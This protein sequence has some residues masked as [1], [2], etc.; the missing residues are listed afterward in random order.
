MTRIREYGDIEDV[1]YA[2]APRATASPRCADWSSRPRD[3]GRFAGP[4]VDIIV[5]VA[6]QS[7]RNALNRLYFL[8]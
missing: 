6:A 7:N 8:I 4:T 1:F 5:P 3:D 2:L